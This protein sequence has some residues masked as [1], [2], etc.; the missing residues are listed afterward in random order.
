MY[1]SAPSTRNLE[2]LKQTFGQLHVTKRNIDLFARYD[3][4]IIFICVYGSVIKECYKL[5]GTRPHPLTVNFIPNMRHPLYI[6][7][8]VS[9]YGLDIIKQV[10][11]NPE[12]PEK[13]MIEMHRIALNYAA[14]YGLGTCAIDVEPDSK[15]LAAP[16]RTLLSTVCKLEYTPES[17]MD[18]ACAI[19]GS[20]LTFV[21]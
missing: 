12:H 18:A 19:I 2:R 10:L 21:R 14:A 11:L 7:S 17:Q 16:V 15:K 3:C 5:G 4:D 1:V 6:L 13:Y 20:G 9:G 8:M